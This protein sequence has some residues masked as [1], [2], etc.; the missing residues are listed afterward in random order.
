MT[1]VEPKERLDT[2][3]VSNAFD[4]PLAVVAL[5]AAADSNWNPDRSNATF[6]FDMISSGIYDDGYLYTVHVLERGGGVMLQRTAEKDVRPGEPQI[7]TIFS[8]EQLKR[9][10]INA[11]K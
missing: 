5:L 11:S 4:L 9:G 10:Y 2:C 3:E 8:W 1:T 7:Q 6:A